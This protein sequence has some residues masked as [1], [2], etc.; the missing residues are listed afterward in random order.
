M[1]LV[2]GGVL[3][4]LVAVVL[5]TIALRINKEVEVESENKR[6]VLGENKVV[7]T[8]KLPKTENILLSAGIQLNPLVAI[9]GV[10]CIAFM[11][12]VLCFV[13]VGALLGLIGFLVPFIVV[14]VYVKL[15]QNKLKGRF[16]EQL[17]QCLPMVAEN[18]RS[19]QT[20]ESAARIVSEYMEDPLRRQFKLF[21]MERQMGIPIDIAMENIAKRTHSRDAHMLAT[22]VGVQS[23]MG[24]SMADTLQSMAETVQ[25]RCHMR[26]RVAA[27]TSDGRMSA[28][29]IGAIPV[30]V[31]GALMF[32]TPDYMNELL[33]SFV[34]RVAVIVSVVMIAIGMW[35]IR[36]LYRI[37]IF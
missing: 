34:G 22:V 17:G 35:L 18:I 37:E 15:R 23:Q 4:A 24:G 21:A 2:I 10:V 19:G 5:A 32:L 20:F 36:K 29:I 33:G 7:Q 31:F 25:R 27:I 12:G 8:I 13:R 16:E 30:I 1:L 26:R 9:A 28:L 6:F 14:G 11:L 3:I